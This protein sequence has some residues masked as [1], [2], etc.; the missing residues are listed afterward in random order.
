MVTEKPT[1]LCPH[2]GQAFT[3]L[4]DGKIP[5]HDYPKPCRVVCRG[6]GENPKSREDTP[7]WKDDPSQ[8]GRDFFDAARTELQLYGFAVVKQMAGYMRLNAGITVCPLCLKQVKF[9]IAPSNGHCRAR[10]ET[11]GCINAVE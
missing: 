9:T 6:S 7:L 1:A 3:K 2:C 10:C 8:E 11:E 5:T 4:K